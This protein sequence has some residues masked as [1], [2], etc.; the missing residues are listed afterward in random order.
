MIHSRSVLQQ[1]AGVRGCAVS[2]F[3]TLRDGK[4]NLPGCNFPTWAP[5]ED[6]CTIFHRE[7][8]IQHI[9]LQCVYNKPLRLGV[10]LPA[11]NSISSPNLRNP[12]WL[13]PSRSTYKEQLTELHGKQTDNWHTLTPLRCTSA[14][15]LPL[16]GVWTTLSVNHSFIQNELAEEVIQ[17]RS[18]GK[19]KRKRW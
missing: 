12:L 5:R 18:P 6:G 19:R 3:G 11:G 9:E 8:V 10:P 17:A 4:E 16:E 15:N 7:R 1:D 13:S 2:V 14:S